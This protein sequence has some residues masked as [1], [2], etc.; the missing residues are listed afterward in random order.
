M[1][2]SHVVFRARNVSFFPWSLSKFFIRLRNLA[3]TILSLYKTPLHLRCH[4]FLQ[5]SPFFQ[6]AWRSKIKCNHF[7]NWE[8]VFINFV[9][10][11]I[12]WFIIYFRILKRNFFPL[13]SVSTNFR[14]SSLYFVFKCCIIPNVVAFFPTPRRDIFAT[15]FLGVTFLI[16]EVCLYRRFLF[17]GHNRLIIILLIG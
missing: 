7:S 16:L 6:R 8:M 13:G 17:R 3:E 2:D 10:I 5:R 15:I 9:I 1:Y 14:C 4:V 11:T 12:P